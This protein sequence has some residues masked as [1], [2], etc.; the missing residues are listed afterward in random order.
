MESS[1][2][3]QSL[4]KN[5]MDHLDAQRFAVGGARPYSAAQFIERFVT[6]VTAT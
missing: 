4:M 1:R 2:V 6:T 5:E 3:P